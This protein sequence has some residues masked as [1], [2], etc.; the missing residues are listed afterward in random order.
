VLATRQLAE[1]LYPRR[2]VTAKQIGLTYSLMNLVNPFIS[3]LPVCHGSGGMAGHYAF[4]GRT[5]GSVIL[6]GAFYLTL[7]L[8]F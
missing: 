4:G 3:G 5:G 6:Y 7:G 2:G 1:D 8:I